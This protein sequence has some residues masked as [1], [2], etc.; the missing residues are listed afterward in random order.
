L[1]FLQLEKKTTRA[2]V[3]TAGWS[4]QRKVWNGW[5][6]C[7]FQSMSLQTMLL[8]GWSYPSFGC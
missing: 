2:P 6:L 5:G 8:S 1:Y 4:N 3:Q 7:P